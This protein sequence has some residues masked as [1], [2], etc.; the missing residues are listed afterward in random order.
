MNCY[1]V[2]REWECDIDRKAPANWYVLFVSHNIEKAMKYANKIVDD[3]NNEYDKLF[4]CKVS[5]NEEIDYLSWEKYVVAKIEYFGGPGTK[6]V[7]DI[8]FYINNL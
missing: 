4:V 6:N 5:L 2:T 7:P 8:L 1:F 3:T